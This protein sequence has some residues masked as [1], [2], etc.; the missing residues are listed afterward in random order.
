MATVAG[1][2]NAISSVLQSCQNRTVNGSIV[3]CNWTD[4]VN[5]FQSVILFG[6]YLASV[7]V[8]IVLIK[9]G[10]TMMTTGSSSEL[11]EAKKS[12]TK[13]LLGYFFMLAGWLLV[14][15]ILTQFGVSDSYQMLAS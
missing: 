4:L 6:I 9:T 13:V 2:S 12:L 5:L 15:Y 8:V 1:N 10:F 14:K 7:V 3:G 11:A